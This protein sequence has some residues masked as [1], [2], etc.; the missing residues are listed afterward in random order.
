MLKTDLIHRGDSMWKRCHL[1]LPAPFLHLVNQWHTSRGKKRLLP[2][3]VES[4]SEGRQGTGEPS[5]KTQLEAQVWS[6]HYTTDTDPMFPGD[7]R[8][9]EPPYRKHCPFSMCLGCTRKFLLNLPVL[10]S[11]GKE[12]FPQSFVLMP[13][14]PFNCRRGWSGGNGLLLPRSKMTATLTSSGI[15]LAALRIQAGVNQP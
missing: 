14:L 12:Q 3:R 15:L 11:L 7:M 6:T 1:P 5:E 2:M 10:L 13:L 8:K 4:A 9:P